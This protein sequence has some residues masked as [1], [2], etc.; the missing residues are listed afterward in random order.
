MPERERFG[1]FF[2]PSRYTPPLGHASADVYL[3][4]DESGWYFATQS[5]TFLVVEDVVT[6]LTVTHPWPSGQRAFQL[7]P[8]RFYLVARDGDVV[9]GFTLGGR[10]EVGLEEQDTRCTVA[11][12]A[13]LF[14]LTDRSGLGELL[15]SEFEAGLARLRAD[16]TGSDEEF[17]RQ[18]AGADPF[19]L[20]VASINLGDNNH[21]AAA[22]GD[23]GIAGERSALQHA[24]RALKAA[25]EWPD[26]PPT[27]RS[28]ILED[29]FG[30][31]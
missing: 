19:S 20:L 17:D 7:A 2:A 13:P 31:P 3:S 11:S 18:V 30:R 10:L 24:A 9:E 26:P 6:H 14:D 5:A 22:L 8:G 12:S 25:G 29:Q 27:L 16:W 4:A 28:L 23:A 1:Y 21:L 15:A